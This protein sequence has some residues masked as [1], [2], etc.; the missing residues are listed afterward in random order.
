MFDK[1][2]PAML[3]VRQISHHRLFWLWKLQFWLEKAWLHLGL[4]NRVL[5]IEHVG[6]TSIRG[7]PAKPIVDISI[8]V[9]NYE[10]AW[11]IVPVMK[12]LGYDYLGEN[13]E[14]REYAF[15]R[16]SPFAS[17]VFVCEPEAEIWQM[18]LRFRDYLRN[19]PEARKAYE[20][21]KRY[22]A[23][24]YADDLSAYQ[25]AKLPFVQEILGKEHNNDYKNLELFFGRS[26]SYPDR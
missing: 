23:Q 26:T 14:L 25:R 13:T 12:S 16:P 6:S 10:R 22:L 7:L 3:P 9:E 11:W 21:L 5:G 1:T 20:N 17:A 24:Q 18:R 8:A 2:L 15:E 4:G 19:H